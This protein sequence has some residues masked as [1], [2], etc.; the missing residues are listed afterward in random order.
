MGNFD[1]HRKIPAEKKLNGPE[2]L[3][4]YEKSYMELLRRYKN[5]IQEIE[6]M[7]KELRQERTRFYTEQ[8]PEIQKEMEMDEVMPEIRAQWLIE[9]RA[10]V[11]KSFKISEELIEHYVTKNLDEFKSALQQ[12]IRMV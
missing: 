11:E 5:E 4:A 9:L 2:T 1:E 6:S 12:E 7:M 8:L 3:I 10:N